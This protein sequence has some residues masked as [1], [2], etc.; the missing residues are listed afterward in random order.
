MEPDILPQ[1]ELVGQVVPPRSTIRPARAPSR[2]PA[3]VSPSR[4]EGRKTHHG[5]DAALMVRRVEDVGDIENGA[6]HAICPSGA[7]STSVPTERRRSR[8]A[9][10][11][12]TQD[13]AKLVGH[14][15]HLTR[16]RR[17]TRSRPRRPAPGSSA[18][19]AF[20]TRCAASRNASLV[21]HALDR[22]TDASRGGV[23]RDAHAGSERLD[24][25]RVFR[26]V[27]DEGNAHQG[28][29]VGER[30]HHRVPGRTG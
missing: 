26:L 16:R 4:R 29:A 3:S 30:L 17:R 25:G 20:A 13:L 21:Q 11:T 24:A 27:S 10:S 6:A 15:V 1:H 12:S 19:I 8:I 9:S 7:A 23:T 5:R 2:C 22:L 14:R 28:H 18:A